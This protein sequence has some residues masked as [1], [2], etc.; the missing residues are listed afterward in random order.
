ML[1]LVGIATAPGLDG[2]VAAREGPIHG[3]LVVVLIV[4]ETTVVPE[5]GVGIAKQL[6]PKVGL[7]GHVGRT[8]A[9]RGG[10]VARPRRRAALQFIV[11][12]TA[13]CLASSTSEGEATDEAAVGLTAPAG[14]GVAH[15]V[16]GICRRVDGTARIIIAIRPHFGDASSRTRIIVQRSTDS[17]EVE[18]GLRLRLSCRSLGRKAGSV[19]WICVLGLL[20]L[21]LLLAR[22]KIKAR[23]VHRGMAGHLVVR[24]SLD[25]HGEAGLGYLFKGQPELRKFTNQ[26]LWASRS[27]MA[28]SRCCAVGWLVPPQNAINSTQ[29]QRYARKSRQRSLSPL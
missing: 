29:R 12:T 14:A 18:L 5:A 27:F 21:L 9:R 4:L 16:R 10:R 26:C 7:H 24:R 13:A 1:G 20:L 28:D 22:R 11:V 17:G 15:N 25:L 2:L 23:Q 3:I 8:D 6:G 19:F